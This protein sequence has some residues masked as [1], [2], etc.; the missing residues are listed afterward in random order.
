ME[1]KVDAALAHALPISFSKSPA[2]E[3][4]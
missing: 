2:E 1:S 4:A 3:E